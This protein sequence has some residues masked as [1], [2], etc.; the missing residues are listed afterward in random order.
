MPIGVNARAWLG[1]AFLVGVMALLLFGGAGTIRYWQ[2]WVFLTI[3][4]VSALLITFYLMKNDPALLERRLYSGPAAEKEPAQKIIMTC[5]SIL[6]VATLVV[7]ALDH[8]FGWST[9]PVYG[10]ISGDAL[11][12]VSFYIVFRVFAANPFTSATVE[13]AGDQRVITTG[14]YAIVRHP[15]Y[16]GVSLLLVATP[17]ALGSYWGLLAFLAMMP[18]LI[19][20]LLDEERFLSAHLAGYR[21]YCAT[22]RWRLVPGIF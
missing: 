5:A 21:E 10:V 8:R 7:P 19:W 9:V 16:A 18:V 2:A 12:A 20:R 13:I 3:Y 17:S 14:P 11:V 15:M 6:F 22:V 4:F 1:I